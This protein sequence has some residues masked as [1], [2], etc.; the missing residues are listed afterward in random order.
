MKTKIKKGLVASVLVCAALGF[1]YFLLPA[2]GV[3]TTDNA[4]VHAEVSHISAEV[5][6]T[7]MQVHVVDNQYVEAGDLLAELDS[8]EYIA[9]RDRAVSQLAMAEAAVDHLIARA[10]LQQVSI[11]EVS[12]LLA[13]AKADA[14][15]QR[16]ELKR[17][18]D[19]LSKNLISKSRYEAQKNR[20]TQARATLDASRMKQA[21]AKQQLATLEVEKERLLAQRDQAKANLE[22]ASLNLEDTAIR[23]PVSGVIGNRTVRTGRFVNKGTLLLSIVPIED[24]WV[25]ANY[26][27]TQITDIKPGQA[28]KVILD[29]FPD[30]ELRGHVISAAPATGAQFSLLSPDNATGNFVKIVQRV[31]VKIAIEVPNDLRGRVVP[32]L[33]AEVV[34]DTTVRVRT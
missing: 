21:A 23:A 28:V 18:S 30:Y 31:P 17:F 11:K 3:V 4:Y 29:S 8:R 10:E 12:A 2:H 9:L 14:Q 26:K 6:G 34:V 15:F 13:S 1:Y 16:N 24:V 32:G 5:P 7:V 25:E 19:L 20:S 33:S 22:L 27:E